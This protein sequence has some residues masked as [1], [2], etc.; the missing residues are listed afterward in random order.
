MALVAGMVVLVAAGGLAAYL[1]SRGDSPQDVLEEWASETDCARV[2]D[3]ETERLRSDDGEGFGEIDPD[4]CDLG[5][6][7]LTRF[8]TSDAEVDGDR[9]SLDFEAEWEYVGD[10]DYEDDE[11]VGTAELVKDDGDWLVDEITLDLDEPSASP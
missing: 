11:L 1:L 7:E 6:W 4:D 8:E 3:L 2:L 5:D 10:E 9:A